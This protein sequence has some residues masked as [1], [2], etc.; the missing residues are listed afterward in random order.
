M[1]AA[2]VPAATTVPADA[3]ANHPGRSYPS[4]AGGMFGN[5][6]IDIMNGGDG[7]IGS[8]NGNRNAG[9]HNG[10][11]NI[12]N[13]NGNDNGGHYNGNGNIGSRNG[14]GNGGSFNGNRNLGQHNGNNN[15]R[16]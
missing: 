9:R 1:P 2:T 7:N 3:P 16:R 4:F 12:G 10:N 13:G 8:D 11:G 15:G 6:D 14:N 5:G